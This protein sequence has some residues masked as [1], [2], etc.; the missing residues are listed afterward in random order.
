LIFQAQQHIRSQLWI[1][2][3]AATQ[4]TRYLQGL[5]LPQ[6]AQLID[7][8][9]STAHKKSALDRQDSRSEEFLLL[10]LE[11]FD[12]V[13][14]QARDSLLRD[15]VNVFDQHRV[16]SFIP[17]RTSSRPLWHKLKEPT[18]RVYKKVWKQL[19]CFVY[20]MVWKKQAPVLHCC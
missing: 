12:R 1:D 19:L 2:R 18:Y 3:T 16:N 14:E 11:S 9:S 6:A 15:K 10:L 20:R 4:W 8:P 13:I 7:I 5:D 17:H